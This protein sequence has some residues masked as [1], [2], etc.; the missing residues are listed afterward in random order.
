MLIVGLH[1]HTHTYIYIVL[2]YIYTYI[3]F[4]QIT[5]EE[6]D[7]FKNGRIP[8]CQLTAVWTAVQSKP[9]R[10]TCKVV[11]KGTKKPSHFYIDLDPV[12][13]GTYCIVKGLKTNVC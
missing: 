13:L 3:L 1:T 12:Q 10:L 4:L 2:I 9:P 7:N 8:S 6:V 5:K 11:L